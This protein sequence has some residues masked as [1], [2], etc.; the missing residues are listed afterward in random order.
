MVHEDQ[1]TCEGCGAAITHLICGSY[2]THEQDP[3][4]YLCESCIDGEEPVDPRDEEEEIFDRAA[5]NAPAP[6]SELEVQ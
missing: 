1:V 3:D 4:Y 5:S 6:Y 2:P